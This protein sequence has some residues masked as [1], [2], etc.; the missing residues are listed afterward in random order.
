M[1]KLRRKE[2]ASYLLIR[3]GKNEKNYKYVAIYLLLLINR[4]YYM[5]WMIYKFGEIK[6]LEYA[7]DHIIILASTI[8]LIIISPE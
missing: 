7:L 3:R 2:T 6:L 4:I 5:G 8:I 1:S